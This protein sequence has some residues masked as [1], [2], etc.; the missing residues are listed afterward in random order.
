MISSQN[1]VKVVSEWCIKHGLVFREMIS[2][3][4][5]VKVV[6]E[7]C[8]LSSN[9]KFSTLDV[10]QFCFNDSV[11]S[12]FNL[13]CSIEIKPSHHRWLDIKDH[14]NPTRNS[15][16]LIGRGWGHPNALPISIV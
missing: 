12:I 1:Q 6:S 3:Q 16:I 5:Q 14:P 13:K 7:W 8:C 10:H 4:N 9:L 15:D 2:S 11:F